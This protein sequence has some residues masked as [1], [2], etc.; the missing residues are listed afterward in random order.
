MS[1][2]LKDTEFSIIICTYNRERF[3][4]LA[5]KSILNQTLSNNL[6]EVVIIDNNSTDSTSE[7]CSQFIRA[8]QD[9]T[10]KYFTEKQQ[11]LSY[12]RNKGI[13]E[14]TGKIITF[15][16][17]DAL[18]APD[19]SERT[20]EFFRR[21]KN[22]SAVGGKILLHYMKGKP[23]WYNP[24][25]APL[26]GYFN[27]GNREN[28]FT[29]TYFKGSNMSF[30]HELF[31]IHT[32]FNTG[33]GRVGRNL[34]GSEE[35]EIF[36][37][38]KNSG[39]KIWYVPDAIVYHLVPPERTELNFIKEQGIGVGKSQKKMVMIKGPI[40]YSFSAVRELAKW[41]FTILLALFYTVTFRPGI[42]NVLLKFRYWVS[43]GLFSKTS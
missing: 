40:Y 13:D 20:L 2:S 4:P 9:M 34:A 29:R 6:F 41:I 1:Q 28:P 33:L 8:N 21:H 16:D 39:E 25:L 38:L 22:V 10:V 35:K 7:I 12:A 17:D 37:R 5:L 32:P 30:R 24:F 27:P 11:G 14:A 23:Y 19:F 3:L 36:Y 26:L 18:L 42:A 15:M 43:S 31:K